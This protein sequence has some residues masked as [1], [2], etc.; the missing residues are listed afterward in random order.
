VDVKQKTPS[1]KNSY[2][3]NSLQAKWNH[4]FGKKDEAI[5]NWVDLLNRYSA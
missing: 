5:S 1:L 4:H 2:F 3:L